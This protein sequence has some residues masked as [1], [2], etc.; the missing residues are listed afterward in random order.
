MVYD[1]E[2]ADDRFP[3]SICC[4]T[5]DEVHN[6]MEWKTFRLVNANL[7]DIKTIIAANALWAWCTATCDKELKDDLLKSLNIQEIELVCAVPDRPNIYL[8]IVGEK[9]MDLE[10]SFEFLVDEKGTEGKFPQD[11][12][13]LQDKGAR[14]TTLWP[15]GD[16]GKRCFL[17]G[18]AW[19]PKPNVRAVL[20]QLQWG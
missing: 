19:H 3:G 15:L 14:W 5:V 7:S 13:V 2:L 1:N 10:T 6:V 17:Q 11:N 4:L 20:L 18:T 9:G 8:E 16:G 12:S